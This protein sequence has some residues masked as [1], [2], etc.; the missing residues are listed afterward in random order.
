MV[1]LL[2]KLR[3]GTA[4]PNFNLQDRNRK[5]VS[6][7][8]L[9]GKPVVIGFWT[10]S[11]QECLGEMESM[12]SLWLKYKDKVTF[13]S[14]SL[15]KEFMKM[16]FFLNLKKDFG[17]TFLHMGDQTDVVKDY[18]IRTFPMYVLI[19]GSGNIAKYPVDAPGEG[20][21][22]AIAAILSP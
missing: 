8:G 12:R 22:A 10:T 3:K 15:D 21:E 7:A 13:V 19:D 11:C 20:M 18:D 5:N 4:A 17:W 2:T 16:I 9:K 14:I 6:L 1:S